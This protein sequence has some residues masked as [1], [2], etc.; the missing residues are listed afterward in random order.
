M[1][2]GHV[3][4]LS[5][6]KF[7]YRLVELFKESAARLGNAGVH[8]AAIRAKPLP[9]DEA[10]RVEAVENAGNVWVAGDHAV[11]DLAAGAPLRF[12]AAENT[13][14]VVL[15]RGKVAGLEELLDVPEGEIGGLLKSNKEPALERKRDT[16]FAG[17]TH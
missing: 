11:A 9:S 1:A 6:M 15:G 12:R 10:A 17:A 7:A 16:G 3:A 8:D 4:E 5:A 2:G 13:K 14:D